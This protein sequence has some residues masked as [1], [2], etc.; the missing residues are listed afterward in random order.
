MLVVDVDQAEPG[1]LGGEQRGLGPVVVLR[2]RRGSRGGRAQVGE[3][4]DVEDDPVDP[5][6]HQR[7]ARHLHRARRHAAL[8]HH[9]EQAVQVGRLRRGQGGLE[10]PCRPPGCRRCRSRPTGCPAAAAR[11]RPAGSWW[12]CPG[13]RSPR[14]CAARRRGCRRPGRERPEQRAGGPRRRGDAARRRRP[15]AAAAS[16]ST[17]TAPAAT[18]SAANVVPWARAPGRA[19]Y[20]SPGWIRCELSERPVISRAAQVAAGGHLGVLPAARRRVGEQVATGRAR[21]GPQL[22][23]HNAA[24]LRPARRPAGREWSGHHST[25]RRDGLVPVGGTA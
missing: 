4:G 11:S 14:S 25:G 24:R 10:R 18:A 21:S 16:V 19:A 9:R 15:P 6:H 1:A 7:V 17:A 13:C 20:R 12:S 2:R 23:A 5:A 3:D 8:A 22:V